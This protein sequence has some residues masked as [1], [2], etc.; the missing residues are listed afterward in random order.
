MRLYEW[1]KKGKL[2]QPGS[3]GVLYHLTDYHSYAYTVDRDSLESREGISTTTNPKLNAIPGRDHYDF[4]LVLSGKLIEDVGAHEYASHFQYVG[5]RKLHAH[6]EDEVRLDAHKI[7]PI[8]PYVLGTVLLFDLFSETGIQWLLYGNGAFKGLFSAE[9]S[10]A[11]RAVDMLHKHLHEWK[12]PIWSKKVGKLLTRE[13]GQF[14][15]DAYAVS[16]RGGTFKD[17]MIELCGKYPIVSHWGKP[18]EVE[19]ARRQFLAPKL[20]KLL[21]GYYVGRDRTKIKIPQV[22]KLIQRIFETLGAGDNAVATLMHAIEQAGLFHVMTPPVVWSGVIRE[23]MNDDIEEAM[24]TIHFL[25]KREAANREWHD[26]SHP[27]D[28]IRKGSHDGTAFGRSSVR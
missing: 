16:K 15:N 21:N 25:G 20:V 7:S 8:H 11:P 28:F 3:Y 22:R 23:V 26:R 5:S 18:M 2:V 13:E 27:D 1:D 6:K 24:K 9:K 17:G 10:A 12:K 19:A 4:K 14:I